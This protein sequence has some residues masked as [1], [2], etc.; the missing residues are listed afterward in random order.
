MSKLGYD[1]VIVEYPQDLF[2]KVVLNEWLDPQ[3]G[4]ESHWH[5]RIEILL[6]TEG[7]IHVICDGRIFDAKAGDVVFVNPNQLHSAISGKIGAQYYCITSELDT[8]V[9]S[10]LDVCDR[11]FLQLRNQKTRIDNHI[12]DQELF[13]LLLKVVEIEKEKKPYYEVTMRG[14]MML[15]L[16]KMLEKYGYKNEGKPLQ[17]SVSDRLIDEVINYITEHYEENLSSQILAEHFGFSLS[18]FCR[19]FKKETG[20]TVTDYINSV[21]LS[22]AIL[23]LDNTAYSMTEI[24]ETVGYTSLNYFNNKFKEATGVT[25]LWYRKRWDNNKAKISSKK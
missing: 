19:Y 16:G 14:Y 24:A 10:N 5:D 21:R 1:E 3:S 2:M 12:E 22:K 8:F 4:F 20:E 18:Y 9:S 15:C 11:Q 23:L 7:S 13:D 17:K 6:I 25:P